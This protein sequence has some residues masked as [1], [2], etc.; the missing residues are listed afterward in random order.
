MPFLLALALRAS[1]AGVQDVHPLRDETAEKRAWIEVEEPAGPV[2]VGQRVAVR[3]TLGIEA[4][5]LQSGMVQP[6]GVRLDLPVQVTWAGVDVAESRVEPR[7]T[8]AWNEAVR[9]ALPVED[10]RDG[11]RTYRVYAVEA[12]LPPATAPSLRLAGPSL[13]YAYATR[14]EEGFLAG[15]VPANRVDAFVS[16]PAQEIEVSPLPEAGR[17]EE[18]SGAVGTFTVE[19]E[20]SPRAI[21]LG[22]SLRLVLRVRGH[23]NLDAFE[24]PRWKEIGGFRVLGAVDS[25][26]PEERSFAIDLSPFSAT[27]RQIPSIPFAFFDPSPPAGY[28]IA[29]TNPIEVEVR[30]TAG[31]DPA[32]SAPTAP[33][34]PK[35]AV[36]RSSLAGW[37]AGAGLGVLVLAILRRASRRSVRSPSP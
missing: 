37:L 27:V 33:A 19:A 2:F 25:K 12:E 15:T 36:P 35:A 20:A 30:R 31:A 7:A 11:D 8:L 16:G 24:A 32:P 9:S 3:V 28:R 4:R 13:A 26:G 5:F 17:P 10:R 22:Q 21:D 6:F 18:F 34:S 14:F 1:L 23:G 29:R